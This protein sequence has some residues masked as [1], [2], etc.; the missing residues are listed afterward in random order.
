MDM[1]S[2]G[3]EP[4]TLGE[5][6]VVLTRGWRVIA[7]S[8]LLLGIAAA[9]IGFLMTPVYRVMTV[10]IA[11]E[12]GGR[13]GVLSSALGQLGGLAAITGGLGFGSATQTATTEALAVLQSRQFL[14]EFIEK[15]SLMPKLFPKKWDREANNWKPSLRKIP[16]P[17]MGYKRFSEDIMDVYQDKKTNLVTVVISW[18]DRE[19]A[20]DW[21]N[22]LVDMVNAR[23]RERAIAEA[24]Q[25]I[26]FL[27][28]ELPGANT[29]EVKSAISSMMESQLKAKALA[30]VRKQYAFRVIDPA[31]ASDKDVVLRPHK[32]LYILMGVIVGLLLGIAAVFLTMNRPKQHANLP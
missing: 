27:Q 1:N 16:T 29:V 30:S 2:N 31:I 23:M 3:D 7:A 11:D 8:T 25:T 6:R 4:I 32:G 26:Q 21:A 13:S 19:E 24:D 12:S 14:Q 22:Q 28:R 17:Y 15:N 10:L 18:T 5:L 9:L 20:A